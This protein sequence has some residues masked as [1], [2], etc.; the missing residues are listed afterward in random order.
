MHSGRISEW[1]AADGLLGRVGYNIG[2]AVRVD[3]KPLV[4]RLALEDWAARC[5]RLCS[6]AGKPLVAAVDAVT[7]CSGAPRGVVLHAVSTYSLRS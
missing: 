7:A 2:I 3:G 6:V 1:P 4:A 5:E